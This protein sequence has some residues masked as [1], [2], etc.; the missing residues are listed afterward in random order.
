MTGR[1]SD[2]V[3]STIH[4]PLLMLS[5]VWAIIPISLWAGMRAACSSITPTCGVSC[6]PGEGR[7]SGTDTP[8]LGA[9]SLS[10]WY[11]HVP[12]E[13]QP[14]DGFSCE[15]ASD[16]NTIG[17]V[18]LSHPEYRNDVQLAPTRSGP[19][20]GSRLDTVSQG[21]AQQ[22]HSS[23]CV[24]DELRGCLVHRSV[25]AIGGGGANRVE[26]KH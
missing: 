21:I 2:C 26:K 24:M 7:L 15:C 16:N 22:H 3:D 11:M 19:P 1:L 25:D 17:E 23:S 13:V 5:W 12:H 10:G 20:H 8:R 4:V 18:P 9:S 6:V 14:K